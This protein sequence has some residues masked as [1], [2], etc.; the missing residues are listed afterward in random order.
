MTTKTSRSRSMLIGAMCIFSTIGLLRRYIPYES[1]FIALVRG[2]VGALFLAL[3]MLAGRQSIDR[4][5]VR[6]NGLLLLLS[7]AAI[8]FNWIFLFEA[9]R[10]TTVA[11]ATLCYYLAPVIVILLSSV[12]LKEKLT[13]RE[14]LC[15]AVS[16]LGMVLVSGVL[17]GAGST[18]GQWKGI[19]FGIAAAALYAFAIL[20]NK[21]MAPVAAYDKTVIQLSAASLALLPYVLLTGSLPVQMPSGIPLLLLLVAGVVHTGIA[22]CLYFG[23]MGDLQ[24]H[25]IAMLS[26][27]DPVIAVF[28]SLIVLGEPMSFL[29]GTGAV[30]I[31][32][33][34]YISEKA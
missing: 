25:T 34:A 19:A 3:V 28:L 11:V 31:L 24:A 32:G 5:A 29:G 16:L 20:M 15:T 26:Y 8:G 9:Y 17:D 4:N 7:G 33:S 21:K 27:L 10:Y 6:S 23:A 14:L 18:A 2:F 12:L 30:L 1:S 13:R 22:Y